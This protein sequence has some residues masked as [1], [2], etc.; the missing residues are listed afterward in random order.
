MSRWIAAG[1]VLVCLASGARAGEAPASGPEAALERAARE[2]E[3]GNL[4]TAMAI[5][6]ALEAAGLPAQIQPRADLLLGILLLRQD[7]PEAAI[8]R[9]EHAAASYPLLGDYALISLAAANRGV[10]QPGAAALA[11]RRVLDSFPDSLFIERASREIVRDW[12]DAGEIARVEEAAGRYL[13]AYPQA[14]GRAGVW[15]ELGEAFLRSGRAAQAEEIFRRVWIELPGSPD[16]QRAKDLLTA[17][18][19]VQ[20][21]TP[22]ERLRRAVTA[23][24]VGRYGQSLQELAPF[25]TA[26]DPH[27]SQA[28]LYL[29]ISAFRLRL[30]GQAAQWLL[31]LREAPGVDRGEVA[32]WLGRSFGRAGDYPRFVEQL[33]S[34]L[35]V[36]PQPRRREEALYLLAQAAANEGETVQARAYVAR[37]IQEYP[38]GAWTDAGL[39]LQGWLARKAGDPALALAA[40]GRLLAEQLGSPNRAQA[41]YWRGRVLEAEKRPKDAVKTY[42]TLLET[43]LDQ[44]YYRLRAEERLARLGRRASA[45]AAVPAKA[46]ASADQLHLKRAQALRSLGLSDE[47]ADEYS[48]QVRVHPEDRAGVAETCRAFL[49]LQRYDKAVWLS[50]RILRPLFIQENGQPPIREYW[51]CLYP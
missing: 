30:Y 41:L 24:Q 4:P 11:L 23:Y 36:T 35:E 29:G 43:I 21:F 40:W 8:P 18:P 7:K 13:A 28:R 17:M 47:A 19:G 33:L 9:L 37:L 46:A 2:V 32:Y 20:P 31:P 49:D 14:S 51:Q 16:A 50:G 26:G 15:V 5:L 22:E 34:L 44:P 39:W 6:Q 12:L 38:K 25:A 1:L 48:E 42:Q 45:P 3:A 27:E 10:G